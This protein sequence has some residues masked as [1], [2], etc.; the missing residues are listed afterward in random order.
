MDIGTSGAAA[1]SA[2]GPSSAPAASYAPLE[3]LEEED[4]DMDGAEDHGLEM[5]LHGVDGQC[6]SYTCDNRS[7]RGYLS[8]C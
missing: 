2:A 1:P 5:T 4:E 3:G 8:I 6:C 7:G